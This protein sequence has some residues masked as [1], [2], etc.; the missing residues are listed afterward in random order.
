MAG[1]DRLGD[2]VVQE[3][4]AGTFGTR[5][6]RVGRDVVRGDR[7]DPGT[8]ALGYDRPRDLA[9]GP[10]PP[11]CGGHL[12]RRALRGA[13]RGD[14]RPVDGTASRRGGGTRERGVVC[15][16]RARLRSGRRAWA[17]CGRTALGGGRPGAAADRAIDCGGWPAGPVRG[18]RGG[19]ADGVAGR[20]DRRSRNGGRYGAAH[21]RAGC[22]R[23]PGRSHPRVGSRADGPRFF[24]PPDGRR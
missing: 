20:T 24:P 23:V 9:S 15:A 18:C 17:G 21:G 2:P 12:A 1:C 10:R 7:R 3:T 11:A 5:T 13:V 4:R 16:P 6:A 14:R 8:V 19:A 22:E